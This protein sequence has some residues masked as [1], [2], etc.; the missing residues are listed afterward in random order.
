MVNPAAW[1]S[2][3]RLATRP[4]RACVWTASRSPGLSSGSRPPR[5]WSGAWGS[6]RALTAGPVGSA[7]G[8]VGSAALVMSAPRGDCD[9]TFDPAADYVHHVTPLLAGQLLPLGYLM[10]PEQARPAAGGRGVLGHE[11]RMAPVRRLLAV[12]VRLGRGQPLGGQVPRMQAQGRR[13][14]LLGGR[15]FPA[16][17]V[18]LGPE[19]L[20]ADGV[21]LP[22]ERVG[23]QPA[24]GWWRAVTKPS[25]AMVFSASW[26]R[27][28]SARWRSL[29]SRRLSQ[30]R[31]LTRSR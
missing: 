12:V 15:A 25:R 19:R 23:H 28:S 27:A 14:S 8:P 9:L 13:G 24:G 16:T 4:S 20:A 26:P 11:H 6:G 17:Q 1:A 22:V 29:S 3:P 7:A 10:P 5:L 31:M 2:A 18:K 21:Q 30:S